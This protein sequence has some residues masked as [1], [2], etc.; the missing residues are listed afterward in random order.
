MRAIRTLAITLCLG[1]LGPA[2][3]AYAQAAADPAPAVAPT[4][5]AAPDPA[6]AP[7]VDPAPAPADPAQRKPLKTFEDILDEQKA[8]KR[9]AGRAGVHL[10]LLGPGS[11]FDLSIS[12]GVTTLID[13]A[14]TFG[15]GSSGEDKVGGQFVHGPW[16]STLFATTL[17][18]RLVPWAWPY[19]TGIHS[20]F[21]ELGAGIAAVSFSATGK[22]QVGAA[23]SYD[24]GKTL[25]TV[26]A[27][28]GYTWR[29]KSGLR[30][31]GSLGWMQLFGQMNLP[32]IAA[33]DGINKADIKEVQQIL[34][35]IAAQE[36]DA[37]VYLEVSVGW[38][39]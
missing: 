29:L 11:L 25:P 3:T 21:L 7:G 10:G 4:P 39:F 36:D 26:V 38:V 12:Y 24:A 20:P 28:L 13:V 16:D 14:L 27:G 35:D 19:G 30:L 31:Q 5:E 1:L 32:T 37:R 17:R 9:D 15:Y 34:D 33:A 8:S 18:G 6:P 23:Y 2:A 22:D